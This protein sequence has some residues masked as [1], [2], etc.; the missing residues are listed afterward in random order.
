MLNLQDYP[1]RD[2]SY[3]LAHAA[4]SKLLRDREIRAFSTSF[5]SATGRMIHVETEQGWDPDPMFQEFVEPGYAS[6]SN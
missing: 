4:A 5:N 2:H 6:P 3:H 1:A